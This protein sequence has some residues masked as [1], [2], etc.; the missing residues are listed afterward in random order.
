MIRNLSV[1]HLYFHSSRSKFLLAGA[2]KNEGMQSQ[3]EGLGGDD[4]NEDTLI[5]FN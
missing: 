2:R 5:T 3:K 1:K 4:D